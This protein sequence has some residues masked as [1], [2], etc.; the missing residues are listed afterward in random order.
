MS[1]YLKWFLIWYGVGIVSMIFWE[2]AL[3]CMI[4]YS[5]ELATRRLVRYEMIF[6]VGLLGPLSA[7]VGVVMIYR[8]VGISLG[9]FNRT[10]R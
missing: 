6:G 10:L 1:E 8:R 5:T 7:V 4:F 2:I 9:L 3:I